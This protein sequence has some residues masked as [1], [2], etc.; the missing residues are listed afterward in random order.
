MNILTGFFCAFT[1]FIVVHSQ[2]SSSARAT[3]PF[4]ILAEFPEFGGTHTALQSFEQ[5]GIHPGEQ[6]HNLSAA[7]LSGETCSEVLTRS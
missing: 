4:W 2:Q 5:L 1:D 3:T 6:S 7:N